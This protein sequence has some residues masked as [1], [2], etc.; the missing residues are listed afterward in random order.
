VALCAPLLAACGSGAPPSPGGRLQRY[1]A[2]DRHGPVG[3]FEDDWPGQRLRSV[4]RGD[5]ASHRT[6][7]FVL[8]GRKLPAMSD[9]LSAAAY[10]REAASSVDWVARWTAIASL[11]ASFASVIV[12]AY[13]WRRSGWRLAISAHRAGVDSDGKL[14]IHAHVTNTGRLA[15]VLAD[16]RVDVKYEVGDGQPRWIASGPRWLRM[17]ETGAE[18]QGDGELLRGRLEP[19]GTLN[20]DFRAVSG[21]EFGGPARSCKATVVAGGRRYSSRRA[22]LDFKPGGRQ[23]RIPTSDFV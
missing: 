16:V 6:P 14:V 5:L 10:A 11:L 8:R 17:V 18:F 9:L 1:D 20:A 7:L 3:Q 23:C 12:T 2:E 4:G 13:L 22:N 19:S 15:V 21:E